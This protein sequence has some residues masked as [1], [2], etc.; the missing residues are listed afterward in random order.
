MVI[1]GTKQDRVS[2]TALIEHAEGKL[3]QKQIGASAYLECSS[4][5]QIGVEE[6]F[7]TAVR[8]VLQP[9]KEMYLYIGLIN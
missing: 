1:V 2:G 8:A 4:M 7:H 9:T 6:V 5:T 3:L